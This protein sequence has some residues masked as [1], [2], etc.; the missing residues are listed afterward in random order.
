MRRVSF[1]LGDRV[2]V[3]LVD[4]VVAGRAAALLSAPLLALTAW[5]GRAFSLASAWSVSAPALLALWSGV[6][7]GTVLLAAL[8]PWVPGR[9]FAVK[10]AVLGTLVA[11]VVGVTARGLLP[12][13]HPALVLALALVT[14]AITSYLGANFTGSTT[15]TSLS[16]VKRELRV[17]IPALAA[18]LVVALV[19]PLAHLL[20]EGVRR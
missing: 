19:V 12:L 20:L 13:D 6:A 18:V 7:A 16:G 8:L 2:E 1:G 10:G 11:A 14:V 15:F 5:N 3:A 9:M 4:L 17:A